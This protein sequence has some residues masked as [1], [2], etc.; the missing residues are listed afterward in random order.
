MLRTEV[1][2]RTVREAANGD[3]RSLEKLYTL[4]WSAFKR[5]V[6]SSIPDSHDALS[7]FH[8]AFLKFAY[9]LPRLEWRGAAQLCAYFKRVL[10]SACIDHIRRERLRLQWEQRNLLPTT[11]ESP[12]GEEEERVELVA[13][14]E[15]VPDELW[16]EERAAAAWTDLLEELVSALS[17]NGSRILDAYREMAH[18]PG[19][20]NWGEHARTGYI[21]AA[22]GL[23]DGAFYPA[24]SR[25]QK[26]V[27]VVIV[28]R[29][30]AAAATGLVSQGRSVR[31]VKR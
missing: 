19:S 20:E 25:F 21:K 30:D 9:H 10:S 17:G 23:P 22:V 5:Q 4:L 2:G 3:P 13:G 8:D 15:D 18:E 16:G 7:A 28:S 1:D 27:Q 29:R 24:H 6:S 14:S 12:D 31:V 11:V 26:T